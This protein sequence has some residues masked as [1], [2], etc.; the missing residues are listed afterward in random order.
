MRLDNLWTE[1]DDM[2]LKDNYA[3]NSNINIGKALGR[4]QKAVFSRARTLGL[5]KSKKFLSDNIHK[6]QSKS[7]S[8]NR[9]PEEYRRERNKE[10]C[11]NR[12][13]W[14]KENDPERYEKI[15]AYH[16]EISKKSYYK[17]KNRNEE[18]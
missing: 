9:K 14:I 17:N 4:T 15:L 7:V 5:K 8:N 13:E 6:A 10:Y 2:F 18:V 1:A 11:R 16:R 3:N 12:R